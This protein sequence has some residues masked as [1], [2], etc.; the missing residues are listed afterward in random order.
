M[1]H[2][3]KEMPLL[4]SEK[5]LNSIPLRELSGELF[6]LEVGA[7]TRCEGLPEGFA[8]PYL[9]PYLSA[10]N[11]EQG[12]RNNLSLEF[13]RVNLPPNPFESG[14]IGRLAPCAIHD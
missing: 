5:D 9:I 2:H 1:M 6:F 4:F 10:T 8:S 13:V 14:E 11:R 3:L 7:D 12:C